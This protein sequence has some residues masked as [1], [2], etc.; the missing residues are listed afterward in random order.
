MNAAYV[1]PLAHPDATL[2]SVGGKG[3]SLVALLNAG[4]PVPGGFHVTTE[5]YRRF[6][7]ENGIQPRISATLQEMDPSNPTSIETASNQITSY[8]EQGNMPVEITQVIA[9]A[10]S[11]LKGIPVAVRSSAT[12]E[13]LPEASFAGQQETY[14]N[15][16][17]THAVLE[18][19]K[20]C[21]ASLWTARAIA[22]RF[23]HKIDQDSVALAVVVQ[24]LI[25]ADAAGIMFTANPINGKRDELFINAA[26]GLGEAIVSGA[27][28]PD[29]IIVKKENR[30]IIHRQTA[31]KA[32]MTIPTDGGTQESP[33]PDT[34]KMNAVLTNAQA[35]ELA[36]LGLKIES[37]YGMPMDVE[38]TL[39]Q[40][41]ST[42]GGFAIVQARPITALQPEW[43][44]PKPGVTYM[45]ASLAEHLP[46]PV[47]PLFGTLGLRT[48]NQATGELGGYIGIDYVEMEYQY[49][50]IN[51]YIFMGFK[52]TGSALWN[53]LKAF[54]SKT[55]L[56]KL[57]YL[58]GHSKERWHDSR[59]ALQETLA[60]WMAF[61]MAALTP[62]EL[63]AGADQVFLQVGRL[64]TVLQSGPVP[65]STLSEALFTPLYNLV[66]RKDEPRASALLFGFD[67][68]SQLA[69]KSLFDLA[70]WIKMQPSLAE[71]LQSLTSAEIVTALEAKTAPEGVRTDTWS[72]WES[73]LQAHLRNHGAAAYDLDFANPTPAEIPTLIVDAIKMYLTGEGQNPYERQQAAAGLREQ[74]SQKVVAR[75]HWP[76]KGWFQKLLKWAQDTAPLREDSL[77]DLG[78]ANP[79]VRLMLGELGRR[80]VAGGAIER[81]DDIYWL[82]ESDATKLAAQ[83]ENGESLTDLSALIPPRKAVWQTHLKL[84]P[85]GV[86]PER[87][88]WAKFV[89]WHKTSQE[90]NVLKGV[91]ASTGRVTAPACVLFSPDDFSK[92]KPGAVLVAVTTTPAWTPLFTM[93]SAIVTDIGGPLSHSSI[94]A[95]EYG[96]PAVLATGHG[97][98]RIQDGQIVTVDG[99]DGTVTLM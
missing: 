44:L 39:T 12:A 45:R 15:I 90:G 76:L 41:A 10:Y 3:V 94:V 4:L 28:T 68:T 99:S 26:W 53:M 33:V 1:L 55:G 24:E 48:V 32:V 6:V 14:L 66:K 97:T 13:D 86:L 57:T 65:M 92:M 19:V 34:K 58:L 91:G 9:A 63:L 17:G 25:F 85:P 77:M 22:Y 93:A 60:R 96:I 81:I 47:S 71:A 21:W 36:L 73:H 27:V 74:T 16:Q 67:N 87:S 18:A 80:F 42:G 69:E 61:D 30:R 43:K 51:G 5:A 70:M 88:G 40:S 84:S 29:T 54:L 52:M 2:E 64:Y 89:P 59:Q 82:E 56:K 72:E 62:S 79:L 23:K 98:R 11:D 83:L 35:R 31:A 78:M 37:L 75:L 20:K 46:N 38:W 8:F 7:A 49:L 95:R 50:L